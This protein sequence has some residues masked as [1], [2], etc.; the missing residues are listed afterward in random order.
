MVPWLWWVCL[1]PHHIKDQRQHAEVHARVHAA[2]NDLTDKQQEL[3]QANRDVRHGDRNLRAT[4]LAL[5]ERLGRV[6]EGR[7][8]S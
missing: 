5:L 4:M 2:A 8:K 1:M 7:D 6:N 3:S